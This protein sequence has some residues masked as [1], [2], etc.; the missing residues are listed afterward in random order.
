MITKQYKLVNDIGGWFVF[1]IAL[2]TYWLTLEPTASYWDCGEFIIQADKLEVGHPP[3]NPIFM[4][5]ARFFANFA[6]GIE[7][8][9]VMVNAMSG[10]FSAL[11]ILLLFWT[12][13][14]L[15]RRLVVK[16]GRR[17]ELSMRQY[18]V[19]MGAG[20]VGSLAYCWSDTFWFSAVEGEVYAF[21]SFCTALVFWLILKWENRA[22]SPHSDR[23]LILIAYI[24][25]V[26]VAVHLLNL[27]CIPAIVLVFVYRKWPGLSLVGSLVAL[28]VS[29][30][31]VFFVLYGLVPGFIKV[32]QVAEL[33]FVN[34]FHL[35][36]NSG[37]LAYVIVM[38]I[39][40]LW[41]LSELY[42][43]KSEWRINVSFILA[44]TLSGVLFI[45]SG[46]TI[47]IVLSVGLII[48]LF[49]GFRQKGLPVRALNVIMWSIT[50]IFIG[51][52]SYALIILR[53]T[54]DTPMNQNS[55]DNVFALAS[56][57]NREQYGDTPLLYGETLYSSTQRQTDGSVR[58]EKGT[59]QYVKGLRDATPGNSS[60][61]LT[62][63]DIDR[64]ESLR[65]AGGDFYVKQDY[66]PEYK[67]NP[68]LN[69]VFPRIHSRQH[70]QS[71]WN[72]V[73]LDTVSPSQIVPLTIYDPVT[74]S[75]VY[76]E[77]YGFQPMS[78]FKPSFGQNLAYFFN[79]QLNHMY[80]RYFLW[81][82]VGRQN[83]INNQAGELDAGNW[84]S[85]IPAVDNARLGDQSLLPDYLGKGNRGRNAYY[86]LPLILGII[87]LIW[88]SFAGRRGIEQFWVVFFLFF[89][90]GIAIV[91]YLNQTPDQPRER[92]YAFAGSFY[93]FAIWIGMGVPGLWRFLMYA[94]GRKNSSASASGQPKARKPL[95]ALR[96]EEEPVQSQAMTDE[97]SALARPS[98]I[99]AA[100][101]V[102]LGVCVPL[103]MVSQTWDDHDRSGRYAARDFAI[104]YLES[105]EPNA[106]VFCNGDNDTFPL[107]YVQEVE[108]IRPDVRII[109]LSY[110][111]SDWYANQHRMQA[112][113]AAPAPFTA[114]PEDIAY[115]K[116]DIA[117]VPYE[118][119]VEADLL[120]SLRALYASEGIDPQSGYLKL[121]SGMVTIPVDKKVMVERGLVAPQ[122]TADI[123]DK[124]RIDLRG[125][126]AGQR[127]YLT[128][129]EILMLDIIA[130]NAEQGWPR[131]IYWA[132]TVGD[133][134]YLGLGPY[135]R[136]TGM[137][138]QLV[139]TMQDGKVA[140]TDRAYDVVTQKYQWGT[141]PG[142]KTDPYYDE[143]ARRMLF[144]VRNSMIGVAEMLYAEGR[145][146]QDEDDRAKARESFTKAMQVVK[147][148]EEKL[149]ETLSYYDLSVATDLGE[150]YGN[151]GAELGDNAAKERG[152]EI[153]KNALLQYAQPM[154][155]RSEVMIKFRNPALTHELTYLPYYYYQIIEAYEGLG[156][157]R[158]F[159]DNLLSSTGWTYDS[160]RSAYESVGQQ[161]YGNSRYNLQDF[162]LQIIALCEDVVRLQELSPQEYALE[163][164][165]IL[166]QDSILELYIE[167]Y[168]ADGG[169]ESDLMQSEAYRKVDRQRSRRLY[170][171]L[172][173][174]Y[175]GE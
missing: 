102:A 26:S 87:G 108:G 109:N 126:P 169:S 61:F 15:V 89:M 14:H 145:R 88:Q 30:G 2:I 9:S 80:M 84:I 7:K 130:T 158:Q 28:L 155:Y 48:L 39:S 97:P 12:I 44:V 13:T 168:L 36:F 100:V 172:K 94:V 56:Y 75:D 10:L 73:T 118:S 114:T 47:G 135:M 77:L 144:G 121:A 45:G 110:L 91:L 112:Y 78:A 41:A 113:D 137:T 134:Y 148:L 138:Y 18:L 116:T 156:G 29:F 38:I 175:Y 82:F 125:T 174:N 147:L 24:I 151:L 50:V 170:E 55:P 136:S 54:A 35:G 105:L 90:T 154:R 68:E 160:L 8:I 165:D 86:F 22:D 111:N 146:Y 159:V 85:G 124:I 123:V 122:D 11:T 42:H 140:R 142:G 31:I 95:K 51:Y 161:S 17:G 153:L 128:L 163:S 5:T 67:M 103:Q 96:D 37:A 16:D 74:K 129:G 63:S 6:P 127:G 40:L 1:V 25:G 49:W 81:N 32:A 106:I 79:Y 3:G 149:P 46:I 65:R 62:Q 143:T 166:L 60:G 66:K 69:M 117:L 71:Y 99:A 98:F 92:D 21:S 157:D 139:P 76:P 59:P 33:L 57:L 115:G 43:Q 23:Y 107:W 150:L 173:K 132:S 83:D 171:E 93:A 19:I 162:A 52:S 70:A 27:L 101:A 119:N 141:R 131:P 58:V 34:G 20:L 167:E 64:N 4:L 104:N 133:Q 164:N 152:M 120:Q 72:W 53:S